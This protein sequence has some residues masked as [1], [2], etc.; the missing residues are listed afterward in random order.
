LVL[1]SEHQHQHFSLSIFLDLKTEMLSQVR[2]RP[3][4]QPLRWMEK[5]PE[6]RQRALKTA[7]IVLES[8]LVL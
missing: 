4:L 6:R 8:S 7:A 1:R 5:G 3:N 2:K